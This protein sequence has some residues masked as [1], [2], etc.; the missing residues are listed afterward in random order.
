M[1]HPHEINVNINYIVRMYCSRPKSDKQ[2]VQSEKKK[3]FFEQAE[4]EALVKLL[5]E[6][7]PQ[8]KAWISFSCKVSV[9]VSWL[10]LSSQIVLI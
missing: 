6:E 9:L 4:A 7:F 10:R 3:I 2:N 8:A 5:E 1:L